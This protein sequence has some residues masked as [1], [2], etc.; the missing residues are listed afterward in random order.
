[1]IL[2]YFQYCLESGLSY[3]T[4]RARM[5]A[6]AYYHHRFNFRGSLG[7]R[8]EVKRF[9]KGALA[10]F[11]PVKDR[12]PSWDLPTVLKALMYSPF[13]PLQS[14]DLRHLTLKTAFL[15]AICSAKRIGEIQ[16]FDITAPYCSVS[17]NGAVLK[18]NANFLP[19]V[20]SVA[21]IEASME[22]APF[23]QETRNPEG[24]LKALCV[25]RALSVYTEKTKNIR[26]SDQL[27]VTFKKGDQGRA[28]SRNTIA[29]WVKSVIHQ[30][31][32]LQDL[33]PPSGVTA[34]ST[35]AQSVSWAKLQATSIVDICKQACWKSSH[36][37]MKHYR[38]DLPTSVS[39]RH[40]E[41]VL[42]SVE[43]Q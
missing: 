5:S 25:C 8:P 4:V 26:L 35:R 7:S 10:K 9:F 18:T 43:Y 29:S 22:F 31:Y 38:L 19:K 2:D 16:A 3:N 13:E 27:F 14:I 40:A 30:A 41:K 21:N 28:V 17:E 36:T 20:S 6:I 34:H 23:G 15:V 33:Q 37:F 1:M 32:S 42:R 24:T 11:P 12:I 39:E